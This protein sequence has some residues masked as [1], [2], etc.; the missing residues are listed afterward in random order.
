MTLGR[1]DGRICPFMPTG[2]Y[3]LGRLATSW[4]PIGSP[5]KLCWARPESG[6]PRLFRYGMEE[7]L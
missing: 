4:D 2:P 6:A 5:C 7:L 1:P 3:P